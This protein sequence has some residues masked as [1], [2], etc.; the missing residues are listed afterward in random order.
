[1]NA[2]VPANKIVYSGVGKTTQEMQEALSAGIM[3]FSVE[4]M[5]ELKTLSRVANEMGCTAPIALRVNP[6][7]D[8]KTHPYISTGLKT[9]KFGIPLKEAAD[10]FEEARRLPALNPTGVHVHIGSQITDLT[11]VQEAI[12]HGV[13]LV[14]DLCAGRDHEVAIGTDAFAVGEV[15]IDTEGPGV[16]EGRRYIVW[17]FHRGR[18]SLRRLRA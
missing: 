13:D 3:L 5:A 12:N 11:P 15:N 7:V 17:V 14:R 9:A 16:F 18:P 4:S 10:A 1:M 8:A 2:G 6:H